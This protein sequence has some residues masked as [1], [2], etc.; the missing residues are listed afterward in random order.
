MDIGGFKLRM[1]GPLARLGVAGL[2]LTM[3]G[4]TAASGIY[5]YMHHEERDER[6]GMTIDDVKAHYHGIVSPAP[7]LEAL[8]AGHP[9]ELPPPEGREQW[10]TDD[11]RQRL[12][13][14][15]RGDSAR[16][17]QDYD[18]LELGMFAPAEIMA[19]SCIDC[20]ARN[21]TGEH[22]A[23]DIP[24]E[25]WD[26]VR[27]VAISRTVQPVSAEI[28]AASTHTHALGM[29]SMGIAMALLALLTMWPRI[30]TGPVIAL[31]GIGLAVDIGSWWLTRQYEEFAYAVVAGGG[32]FSA[33]MVLLS[34]IVLADLCLPNPKPGRGRGGPAEGP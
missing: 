26:D 34:L 31:T 7:L 27:S 23:P 33:G 15:L 3:L 17:N 30:V 18:N 10:L 28:L 16:L 4:G 21:A 11:D 32:M 5:L 8:E 9:S 29:S 2:V 24:L 20:H 14:W 25:Y 6:A 13:D 12:I 1:L 19:V 22:A